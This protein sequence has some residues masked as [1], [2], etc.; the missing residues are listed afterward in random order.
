[1]PCALQI[2]REMTIGRK[3]KPKGLWHLAKSTV[4]FKADSSVPFVEQNNYIF[5]FAKDK[6]QQCF[7]LVL[8]VGVGFFV[9]LLEI[10]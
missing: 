10:Y 7:F 6:A 8:G 9:Y 2:G 4:D 1:M 5:H 3:L